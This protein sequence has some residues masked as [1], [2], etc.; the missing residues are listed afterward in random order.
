MDK[1]IENAAKIHW[2]IL[3]IATAIVTIVPII[4]QATDIA[5]MDFINVLLIDSEVIL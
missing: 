2:D 4:P 1:E 3:A 5:V